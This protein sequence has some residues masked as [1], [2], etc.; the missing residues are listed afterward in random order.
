MSRFRGVPSGADLVQADTGPARP[1]GRIGR[2]RP[3]IGLDGGQ[4]PVEA[5]LAGGVR[6]TL[7][8]AQAA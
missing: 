1:Q 5:R 7:P 6:Q 4:C 2:L 8:A 3:R